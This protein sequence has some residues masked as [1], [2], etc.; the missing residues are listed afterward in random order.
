[1]IQRDTLTNG[2][3]VLTENMPHVRSVAIGIWIRVGSRDE[4]EINNGISHFI[5]HLMFKGTKNRTAK[6]IAEELDAVGGQLNAFTSKEYTCY[7][8]KVLDEHVELAIEILSDMV[9]NSNFNEEDIQKERNVILE[10]IKM[11]EDTPDDI[12]HDI[13][14]FS[15]LKNHPLGRPI[16]GTKEIIKAMTRE[17]L[18]NFYKT[19]YVPSNIIITAA[20]NLEHKLLTHS[21]GEKF[22]A[23]TGA[24]VEREAIKPR[25]SQAGIYREKDVEQVHLCLGGEGL[26]VQHKDIY[27]LNLLNNILGGGLSSRLFQTIR[28]QMGLAYSVYS[29]HSSYHETGLFSIYAGLS[30][31][32]LDKFIKTVFLELEEIKKNGCTEAEL[33][34]AK[35]QVKGGIL[36]GLESSSSRMSRLGKSILNIGQLVTPDE[37]IS[38]VEKVSLNELNIVANRIF[39]IDRFSITA[40]GP[41]GKNIKLESYLNIKE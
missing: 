40:V 24:G 14:N 31:E 15:I 19:N 17:D 4:N 12:V 32:N 25:I 10:E 5:E 28:E 34:R 35:N 22:A 21:V 16:I 11:Y 37:I 9:L 20:G 30:V 18:K 13:F 27:A 26:P 23:L 7:Y 41:K 38:R 1:M 2:I 36:L 29:Y 8:V 3:Q 33:Q 6:Q 39:D